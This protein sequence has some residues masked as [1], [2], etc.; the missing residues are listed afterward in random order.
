M[1]IEILKAGHDN[2]QKYQYNRKYLCKTNKCEKRYKHWEYCIH[3]KIL[4]KKLYFMLNLVIKY[5][6]NSQIEME[7]KD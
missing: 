4:I 2:F 1:A 6:S 3:K 5:I 7:L